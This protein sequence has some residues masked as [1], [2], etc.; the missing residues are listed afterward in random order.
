MT[1]R[2]SHVAYVRRNFVCPNTSMTPNPQLTRNCVCLFHLKSELILKR[3]KSIKLV[4]LFSK[5]KSTS[6]S[7]FRFLKK[8]FEYV[9]LSGACFSWHISSRNSFT[10]CRNLWLLVVYIVIEKVAFVFL[11]FFQDSDKIYPINKKTRPN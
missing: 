2:I 10:I 7:V 1:P 4:Y 11:I 6:Y 9:I 5:I 3:D 8:T